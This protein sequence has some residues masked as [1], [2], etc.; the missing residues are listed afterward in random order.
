MTNVERFF[1]FERPMQRYDWSTHMAPKGSQCPRKSMYI[2]G[3]ISS[4]RVIT[5][6]FHT[7]VVETIISIIVK[8]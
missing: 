1:C 8:L 4:N 5:I 7:V 2:F 6:M 3:H